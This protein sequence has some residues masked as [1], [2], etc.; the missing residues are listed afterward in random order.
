MENKN[1]DLSSLRIERKTG[2]HSFGGKK[3]FIIPV[4]IFLGIVIT[5]ALGYLL[6]VNIFTKKLMLILLRHLKEHRQK[7][8]LY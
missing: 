7:Q 6:W 5:F 4:F 8:V 2:N 1:S 3:K